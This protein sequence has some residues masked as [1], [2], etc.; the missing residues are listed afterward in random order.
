MK[1]E[2]GWSD[3]ATSQEMPPETGRSKKGDPLEPLEGPCPHLDLGLVPPDCERAKVH[4]LKPPVC[5]PLGCSPATQTPLSR[6]LNSA[7]PHP[8]HR[9]RGS[10]PGNRPG[11]AAVS[12]SPG[13]VL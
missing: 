11:R 12:S 5:G 9:V 2:G 6:A 7:P 4:C 10:H 1:V 13:P 8:W 3:V